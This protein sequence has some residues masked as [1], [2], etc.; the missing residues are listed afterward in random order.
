MILRYPKG[1]TTTTADFPQTQTP[2]SSTLARVILRLC[3]AR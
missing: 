3:T 1:F 2:I